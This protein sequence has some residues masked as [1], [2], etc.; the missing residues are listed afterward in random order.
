MIVSLQV[1]HET[2]KRFLY[3]EDLDRIDIVLAVALSN[4]NPTI[5]LWLI[6]V[7]AS[8]DMKSAQLNAIRGD[9]VTILHNLTSKSLVNGFR[10]KKKFPDLAPELNGKI[11]I[12]PD[13][14]QILKL[15]PNEKGELWGQLRDLYDGFAGK[16]SGM[17]STAKYEKLKVTLL[18]GSTNAIDGQILVHQDLGTRE[19][20]YRTKGN[21]NKDQAMTRCFENEEH[22]EKISQEL[23]KITRDFL[24]SCEIQKVDIAPDVLEEIKHISIYVTFMRCTAEFD[25][26]TNEL[27]NFVYP[28]EPTRISK[29][30]K[31]LYVCLKSL[32]KDYPDE[33]ALRILWHVARSS[34]FP[35]RISIFDFVRENVIQEYSTSQL[36]E[37]FNIGKG[38][39]KRE[40]AVLEALKLFKCRR[41]E[42]SRPDY[43][44]EYWSINSTNDFVKSLHE[45]VRKNIVRS[46][47]IS[48]SNIHIHKDS[49]PYHISPDGFNSNMGGHETKVPVCVLDSCSFCG[50]SNTHVYADTVQCFDCK[51]RMPLGVK[52]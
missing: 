1:L 34:A 18:A 22:E 49:I 24:D 38:T 46:T 8:G 47:M 26:Y 33:T 19:F 10:D 44:Y 48:T 7:G 15:P 11:V 31:R 40:C 3:I 37:R 25:G 29:Q 2:Y 32:S 13:M 6:L 50:S 20:I 43:F 12:V 4:K 42:T 5:P 45:S 23:R 21:K 28:E 9:D 14:A 36:A 17:G 27:R 41:Q 16:N 51:R 52:T 35:I 39:A 30:L